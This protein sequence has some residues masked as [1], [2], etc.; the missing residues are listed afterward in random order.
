MFLF[1]M[2]LLKKALWNI[3]IINY[4]LFPFVIDYQTAFLIHNIPWLQAICTIRNH[5]S[6]KT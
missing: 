4:D 5:I 2:M 1:L 3:E 6:F